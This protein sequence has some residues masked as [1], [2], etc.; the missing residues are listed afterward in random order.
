MTSTATSTTTPGTTATSTRATTVR[1]R[2]SGPSSPPGARGLIVLLACTTFIFAGSYLLPLAIPAA[3]FLALV[4][5]QQPWHGPSLS[6][7]LH[8]CLTVI[9][10]AMA[11]QL[12][13]LPAFLVDR[14][15]PAARGIRQSV[16]LLEV[17]GALPLTVDVTGTLRALATCGAMLVVF[18][19][20][21]QVFAV[22]GVR[23]VARAI[24][25]VGLALSAVSLAQ[26]ATAHGLIYWRWNPG[27]G[28]MPFGPFLNRNHF[29]TWVVL[30]VPVSIGY[31]L[32]HASAHSARDG[33]PPT[34]R[35]RVMQLLDARSIWL[36]AAICLMLVA[37]AASL[38]RSGMLGLVT[39]VA[40]G[41][42]LVRRRSG[43]PPAAAWVAAALGFA[44]VGIAIRVGPTDVLQRFGS[45]GAAAL[46]RVGI[47]RA[48]LT[49]VKNFWLTGCGAGAFETVMLVSQ[50]APSLFRINAAH[51]HY[52]QLAAEGG[53][54]IAIPV[55]AALMLFVRE[56]AAALAR[57]DS[58]MYFLRAGAVCSLAGVA[59][60][61][62]WETGLATPA[63][64][65]LA[66]IVAA[67]AVHRSAPR[68]RADG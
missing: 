48:A 38:S 29:A 17:H 3:V 25:S 40:L 64:G 11:L 30:A 27:E 21:R 67:I 22:G 1:A 57:D 13:P 45:A 6:P 43:R 14:L 66:A 46:Y 18:V 56:S 28:P 10:A 19:M 12:V 26:D 44:V 61:S 62:L 53:L 16:S 50:Q 9:A 68:V 39:A 63:N 41:L 20:G 4:A 58:G 49:V 59:V 34:W 33:A 23:L 8:A 55:V 35:H 65:V 24:A 2:R 54:L 52:L 47:W 5:I 32:A 36:S 37:L 60:Q 15:S 51:N 42:S 7:R 31:L